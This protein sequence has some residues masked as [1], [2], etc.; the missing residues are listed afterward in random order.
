[1]KAVVLCG[2]KGTR[3]R[4][5]TEEV[6]K[7][8]LPLG[9]KPILQ[10]ILENARRNGIEEV[11]LTV[12]YKKEQIKRYFGD[13]SRFGLRVHYVEED[14]P[15]N[16]AGSVLPLKGKLNEP[17]FV[18]MGDHLTNINLREMMEY[19]RAKGA[20]ATL[21]V[22]EMRRRIEY[23]VVELNGEEVV[24][25][26][27]KP[28]TS[29]FINTAIYVFQPK[30]FDYINEGEDFGH[31]VL[32]R[33]VSAGEMVVAYKFDESWMDI[34]RVADYERLNEYVSIFALVNDLMR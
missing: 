17:F 7:P 31:D 33:M 10:Y 27:E 30:V 5:Y 34:G 29:Y 2:G 18:L 24:G 22:K 15:R 20:T 12:G 11:Y 28:S 23:G 19:H 32:P 13:G 26:K 8:M 1:M 14:Q 25:F 9:N 21:A 4:P 3:L 16:T 6:P